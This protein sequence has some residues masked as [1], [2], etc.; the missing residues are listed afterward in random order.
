MLT[1]LPRLPGD[2]PPTCQTSPASRSLNFLSAVYLLLFLFITPPSFSTSII[3]E[4]FASFSG[5]PLFL[6]DVYG[7]LMIYAVTWGLVNC[8]A[9]QE[10]HPP[11]G[12][13]PGT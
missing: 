4:S 2:S 12:T 5:L 1:T 11:L 7:P 6:L 9:P 13:E 3:G 8:P 10:G